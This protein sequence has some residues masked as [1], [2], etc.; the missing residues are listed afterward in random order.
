M[1]K[2]SSS[3][4]LLASSH[5]RLK[6]PALLKHELT[7]VAEL[8]AVAFDEVFVS[9]LRME[10]AGADR[11]VGARFGLSACIHGGRRCRAW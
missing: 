1:R 8:G 5:S 4:A 7:V 9:R 3:G 2:K 10:A 6:T 11:A